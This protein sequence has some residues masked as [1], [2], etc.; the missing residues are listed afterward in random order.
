MIRTPENAPFAPCSPYYPLAFSTHFRSQEKVYLHQHT[1]ID[2]THHIH[3]F[4]RTGNQYICKS[5]NYKYLLI[6]TFPV[7]RFKLKFGE[8]F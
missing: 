2:Q 8:D 1:N 3:L 5:V 6:F 7:L 4:K